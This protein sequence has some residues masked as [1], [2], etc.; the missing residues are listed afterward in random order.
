MAQTPG[1][2]AAR[3]IAHRTEVLGSSTAGATAPPVGAESTPPPAPPGGSAHPGPATA[4]SRAT[5]PAP[6]AAEGG[7]SPAPA[8]DPG[9]GGD[10][11]GTLIAIVAGCAVLA[12]ALLALAGR[13]LFRRAGLRA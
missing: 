1:G 13:P 4:T 6:A 9:G 7:R 12:A 2:P 8:P 5:G 10:G 11:D 3:C